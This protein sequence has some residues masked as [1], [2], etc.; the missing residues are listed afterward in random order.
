L[1]VG[2]QFITER[3]AGA[4]YALMGYHLSQLRPELGMALLLPPAELKVVFE[5]ALTLGDASYAPQSPEKQLKG[6]RKRLEKALSPNARIGLNSVVGKYL[7]VAKP[8][9][10]GRYIEGVK[11]TPVR[12]A[13]LVSGDFLAVKARVAPDANAVREL[14]KFAVGGD[15]HALR[16]ETGT[17]L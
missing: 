6:E 7:R 15:L 5:A 16:V 13:A 11:L 12:T 14:L 4:L 2:E 8:E 3:D 10:F 9:D 1:V 17:V